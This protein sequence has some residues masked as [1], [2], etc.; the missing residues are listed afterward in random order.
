MNNAGLIKRSLEAFNNRD[1]E[2]LIALQ[3][4]ESEFVPVTAALEGT[5]YRSPEETRDFVRSLDLDWE[6]YQAIPETFYE[7]DDRA[8]A[9]GTV[10]ARGR[11][12]Q[13]EMSGQRFGW[14]IATRDG[15]IYRWRTHTD[16]GEALNAIGLSEAELAEH[17]VEP[18]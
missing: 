15:L 17:Q 11:G 4:P 2:G 14:F 8:L 7:V 3:H 1:A 12:S 16:I 5:V 13:V 6:I 18:R 9:L 10:H